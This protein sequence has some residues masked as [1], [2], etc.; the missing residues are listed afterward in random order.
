MT[1]LQNFFIASQNN[2]VPYEYL[3]IF[4]LKQSKSSFEFP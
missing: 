1:F 3:P 4:R 2:K